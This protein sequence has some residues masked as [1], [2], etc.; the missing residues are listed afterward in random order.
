MQNKNRNGIGATQSP[1]L[2][3]ALRKISFSK[4]SLVTPRVH[5]FIVTLKV[6]QELSINFL[7]YLAISVSLRFS[8]PLWNRVYRALKNDENM[9][10]H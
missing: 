9:I 8:R 2:T 1:E 10:R 4:R 3:F 6:K 7:E 5:M